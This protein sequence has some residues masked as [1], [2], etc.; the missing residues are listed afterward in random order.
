MSGESKPKASRKVLILGSSRGIGE[1]VG[2]RFAENGDDVLFTYASSQQKAEAIAQ[3]TQSQALKLD[4]ADR[5]GGHC[6]GRSAHVGARPA[7]SGRGR[8]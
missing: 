8:R 6:W 1:A 5:H 4:V 2:R 3:Q 7:D